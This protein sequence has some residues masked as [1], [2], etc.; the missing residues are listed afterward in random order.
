[1]AFPTKDS[2]KLSGPVVHIHPMTDSSAAAI[3][4]VNNIGNELQ[5]DF[6]VDL[7]KVHSIQPVYNYGK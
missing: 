7:S 5:I 1:M 4:E 6:G 3:D 2:L